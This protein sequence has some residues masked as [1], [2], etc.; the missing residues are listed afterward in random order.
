VARFRG[1]GLLYE[2]GSVPATA[3]TLR[4]IDD[5]AMDISYNLWYNR[6]TGGHMSIS[7]TRIVI[8]GGWALWLLG[9]MIMMSEVSLGKMLLITGLMGF[10]MAGIL[11]GDE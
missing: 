5:R 6:G 11:E 8:V 9:V 7:R 3:K 1:R 10:G 4:R 2:T